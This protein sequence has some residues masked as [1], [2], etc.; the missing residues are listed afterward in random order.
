V[1]TRQRIQGLNW[2]ILSWVRYQSW[3]RP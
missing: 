3:M 1:L 2:P